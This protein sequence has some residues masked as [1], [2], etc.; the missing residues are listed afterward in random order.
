MPTSDTRE[1]LQRINDKP[2]TNNNRLLLFHLGLKGKAFDKYTFLTKCSF[3]KNGG[4]YDL[5]F[6]KNTNQFSGLIEVRTKKK[7]CNGCELMG[8]VAADI[9]KLLPNQVGIYVGLRKNGY[10]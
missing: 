10:F 6:P 3:S 8:S 2:F 7:W 9:G 4:I 5:P 1:E